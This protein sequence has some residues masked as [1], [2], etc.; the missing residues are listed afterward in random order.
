MIMKK[1]NRCTRNKACSNTTF[2]PTINITWTDLG[3]NPWLRGKEPGLNRLTY[4]TDEIFS[5]YL[6][7][8]T[9]F[10]W[11]IAIRQTNAV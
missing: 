6:T 1:E 5:S 2:S 3:L 9:T 7:V 8:N 10:N 11:L 4:F